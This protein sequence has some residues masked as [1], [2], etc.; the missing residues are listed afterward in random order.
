M[1]EK[2]SKTNPFARFGKWCADTG[3]WLIDMKDWKML[4]RSIPS[5]AVGLYLLATVMMNLW[6]C[7]SLLSYQYGEGPFDSATI[8]TW[9]I[10]LSWIP[11]LVTDVLTKVF[12]AKASIKLSI[13]GLL[14][15]L[16]VTLLSLAIC[17]VPVWSAGLLSG[18]VAYNTG[19]ESNGVL[20]S[21]WYICLASSIAFIVSA[22]VNAVTNE[23][24]GKL[25][26]KNPN[27]RLAFMV[28]SY[29]STM[30]GQYIDNFLFTFLA[31]GLFNNLANGFS[32]EVARV[33]L[34]VSLAAGLVGALFELL[35]EAVFSPI[36]YELSKKWVKDGVGKQYL[37]YCKEM[38]IKEDIARSNFKEEA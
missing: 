14:V 27:G 20:H 33:Q 18:N 32:P 34:I 19:F 26:K 12:G 17:E 35:V 5:I 1:E 22:I 4:F 38:E 11:F 9:G 28:R 24:I 23:G 8:A 21:A 25:F 37:D 2:T 16:G 15:N 31:F 10:I 7:K 6:A 30:I 3:K 29:S 36:G 13:L